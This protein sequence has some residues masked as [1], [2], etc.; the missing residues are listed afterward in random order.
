MGEKYNENGEK[1]EE[2]APETCEEL[3]YYLEK[4]TSDNSSRHFYHYTKIKTAES[5][6]TYEPE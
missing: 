6:F 5:Q 3:E 1:K 4:Y 2:K